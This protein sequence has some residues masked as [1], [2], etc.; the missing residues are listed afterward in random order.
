MINKSVLALFF[1]ACLLHLNAATA[2]TYK[3]AT[4]SPDGLSWMKKLRAGVKEIES[5]TDGRVKFKIYPGGVQGDD[6]T[7]LRKMRIGQL[8]GGAL[9][10]GSL[11]RF[12]PD[13]QIYNLPLQFQSYEEVDYIRKEMDQMI[14][15]GLA[16]AGIVTFA[17]SE[18]GFAYLLTQEPVRTVADL[19]GLK[20]WIPDNDPIA[21][22]LI[23]SFDVSPIP[24]GITDVLAGLQTGLIDAVMAPPAVALALQWHNHVSYMTDLPLVYIYSMLAMDSKAYQRISDD[25]KR[26]VRKVVDS[27]FLEMESENRVDNEKA[28]QALKSIGIKPIDPDNIDEWRAVADASIEKLIGSGKITPEAVRLYL[29]NLQKYRD[30]SPSA[31]D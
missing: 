5:A 29:A 12:F 27:M 30:G 3:I 28:Y 7:V 18:T 6:Q 17:F 16:E 31:S 25:D 20:A 4:I 14:A 8:H 22:E 21:A 26:V 1:F 23:K 24:L 11:T 15:D 2:A 13:L 9:A 19:K 10:A